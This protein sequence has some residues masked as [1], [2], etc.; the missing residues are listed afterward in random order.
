MKLLISGSIGPWWAGA[1]LAVSVLLAGC[2]SQGGT[3]AVPDA[4]PAIPPTTASQPTTGQVAQPNPAAPTSM[5]ANK[6]PTAA[7]TPTGEVLGSQPSVQC[8]PRAAATPAQTEG[9]YYKANPP[10][11]SSLVEPGMAGTKLTITG[12]VLTPDCRPVAGA[13]VDFWQADDRGQYDN[14]GYRLRGYQLTGAD[15]RY[16]LETVVPGLYP[17]RTRHIHVKV[18]SPGG[19]ILTTQLY[20]PNEPQNSRDSIFDPKLVMNVQDVSGGKAAAFNFVVAP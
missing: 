20:F 6:L 5:P 9:P 18:Q 2:G 19:P 12:Y 11:R 8:T 4:S 17:G 15:G 1:A 14:A 16:T 10:Q 13:R 7:P 3:T